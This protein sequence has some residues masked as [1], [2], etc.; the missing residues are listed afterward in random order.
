MVCL[1]VA[2]RSLIVCRRL[3][4]PWAVVLTKCVVL[5]PGVRNTVLFPSV[6]STDSRWSAVKERTGVDTQTSR[7]AMIAYAKRRR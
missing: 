3:V 7:A 6:S 1:H 5:F 2:E 4:W